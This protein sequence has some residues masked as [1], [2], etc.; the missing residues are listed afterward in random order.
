MLT[1]T[2][3]PNGVPFVASFQGSLYPPYAKLPHFTL[4]PLAIFNTATD[5]EVT[6]NGRVAGRT[7]PASSRP[8]PTSPST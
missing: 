5:G 4:L 3:Y 8:S 1:K 7:T 2:L 6:A